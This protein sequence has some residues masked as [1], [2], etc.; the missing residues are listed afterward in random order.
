MLNKIKVNENGNV[1]IYDATI[2]DNLIIYA[3]EDGNKVY[4]NI[5]PNKVEV[6]KQGSMN[7]H[8]IHEVNREVENPIKVEIKGQVFSD[9]VKIL[10]KGIKV[11]DTKVEVTF[12]RDQEEIFITWEW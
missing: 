10:T 6:M 11:E 8:I 7:Y 5:F 3:D 1:K 9:C 2:N 4:V 12:I